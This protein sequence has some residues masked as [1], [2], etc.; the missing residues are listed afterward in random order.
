MLFSAGLDSAVLLA[1]TRRERTAQSDLR[2]DRARLGSGR[3]AGAA[4]AWSPLFAIRGIRGRSSRCT[5]D[6]RDVYPPTHWAIRG[7]APAFDTPD[8]DVYLEGRNIV[9]LSKAAV[10]MARDRHRAH[11]D[12]AARRQ[13]LSGCHARVLRG[14]GEGARRLD[15]RRRSTIEAP[16]LRGCTS[17]RDPAG[18]GARRAASS[19]RC[20][21][22]SP[23][24]GGTAGAAASAASVRMPFGR[25]GC[26][27]RRGEWAV[28]AA[29]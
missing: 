3:A 28:T 27:I 25:W 7:E 11:R 5:F 24:K 6:M 15:W 12:R 9:L 23:S 26:R 21:A 8:E 2:R 4:I 18:V 16:L 22:C 20:P 17:R 29:A 13:S 14:D 1:E 10:F 19:S